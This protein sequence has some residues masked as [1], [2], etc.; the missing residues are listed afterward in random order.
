MREGC[1]ITCSGSWAC[2]LPRPPRWH[3]SPTASPQ[4]EDLTQ[5]L[6]LAVLLIMAGGSMLELMALGGL[7]LG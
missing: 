6:I 3:G 7:V 1:W 4:R 5:V 2:R